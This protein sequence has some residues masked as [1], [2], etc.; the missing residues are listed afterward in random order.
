MTRP[1]PYIVLLLAL[2][3]GG[4]ASGFVETAEKTHAVSFETVD[5]FLSIEHDRRDLYRE[6]APELHAFAE[7]LR[8]D[9]PAAFDRAWALIQVYKLT[10]DAD[11]RQRAEE[12]IESVAAMAGEARQWL[13]PMMED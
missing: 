6:Q 2:F 4:C 10:R 12:A 9:A 3:A 1:L 11:D 7:S 8:G 13:V 5:T